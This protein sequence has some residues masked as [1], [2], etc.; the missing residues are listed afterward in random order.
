MDEQIKALEKELKETTTDYINKKNECERLAERNCTLY[1]ELSAAKAEV[2]SLRRLNE[3]LKE[4]KITIDKRGSDILKKHNQLI[5]K[6]EAYKIRIEKLVTLFR[7]IKYQ[8]Q[9]QRNVSLIK[10]IHNLEKVHGWSSYFH[11]DCFC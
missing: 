5:A 3:K 10:Y 11:Y 2:E 8:V 1:N 9:K 7:K 4:E 6:K